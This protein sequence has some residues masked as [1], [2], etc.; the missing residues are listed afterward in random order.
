MDMIAASAILSPPYKRYVAGNRI[1]VASIVH[2]ISR[3]LQILVDE[4]KAVHSLT[5]VSTLYI[6]TQ[7]GGLM[8]SEIKRWGNSCAVRL[9][10]ADLEKAGLAINDSVV[11]VAEKVIITLIKS[12]KPKSHITLE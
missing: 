4:K 5:L 9:P 10:R 3:N 6:L 11:I 8:S 12:K 1:I 7:G 2:S